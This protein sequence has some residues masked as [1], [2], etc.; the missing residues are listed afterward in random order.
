MELLVLHDLLEALAHL[1]EGRRRQL[2]RVEQLDHVPAELRLHGLVSVFTGLEAH[3]RAREFRHHAIGGEP[4]EV[5]AVALGGI[6]GLAPG[7][8]V[9]LLTLAEARDD[10][11]GEGLGGDQDVARVVFLLRLT[12]Q[13]RLVFRAQL[14]LARLA[15]LQV[16]VRHRLLQHVEARELE[17]RCGVGALVETFFGGL[18]GHEARADQ[19][20]ER[21][22]AL[23]G[24]ELRGSLAADSLDVELIE[25][26]ADGG[27]VHGRY[28]RRDI[29]G[30]RRGLRLAGAERGERGR[31]EQ[32][33]QVVHG[34]TGLAVGNDLLVTTH[35]RSDASSGLR[36]TML[37]AC[38]ASPI[39]GATAA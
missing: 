32:E 8:L 37:S 38:T 4:A 39:N 20:V 22:T 36:A 31:E 25:V 19:V 16:A 29:A 14:L 7:E 24:G 33:T 10:L 3:H 13:L 11:L 21:E 34:D 28:R 17:E 9:E 1:L 27:A 35:P 2:A 23:L 12:A 26:A 15:I 6:H 30:G 18:L 5:A